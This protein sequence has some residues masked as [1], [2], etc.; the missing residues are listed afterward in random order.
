VKKNIVSK[1]VHKISACLSLLRRGRFFVLVQVLFETFIPA[2]FFALNKH[3]FFILTND[4]QSSIPNI[5]EINIDLG[6]ETSVAEIVRDLYSGDLKALEFYENF[7]HNG[8]DVWVARSGEN[9]IGV[10]WLYTGY[11][12]ANWEGYDAW[13]LQIEIEPTAKFLANIFV[14]PS[15]RGRKIF[16]A[17]INHCTSVYRNSNFYSCVD[18]SNVTSIKAHER[19]G[20]QW[21]AVAYYIR[22]FQRTYCIFLTKKG[23]NSWK[24]FCFRL[25][26]GKAV[27]IAICVSNPNPNSESE[28]ESDSNLKI[29]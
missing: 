25:P 23:K 29:E 9:V 26:R 28:S 27:P 22:F 1:I 5:D 4:K 11:Y 16:P 2:R 21:C 19:I 7:Y 10:V 18:E 8:I 3:F 14:A 20:F 12:L 17:I 13:L 24:R 15:W 6:T